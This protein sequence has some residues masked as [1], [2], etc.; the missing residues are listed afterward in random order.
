MQLAHS[1]LLDFALLQA[2]SIS[3]RAR[4]RRRFAACL[5]LMCLCTG[6]TAEQRSRSPDA[7]SLMSFTVEQCYREH[8]PLALKVA[9]SMIPPEVKFYCACPWNFAAFKSV[10]DA[11]KSRNFD[12]VEAFVRQVPPYKKSVLRQAILLAQH[13]AEV[14]PPHLD[15]LWYAWRTLV[16]LHALRFSTPDAAWVVKQFDASDVTIMRSAANVINW[17]QAAFSPTAY[18]LPHEPGRV[19]FTTLAEV[20]K[21]ILNIK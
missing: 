4:G 9:E 17:K 13:Q 7:M 20:P 19:G 15:D 6:T 11:L 2:H 8:F 18:K 14:G 12:I 21:I 5:I 3:R 10:K 1:G 16:I